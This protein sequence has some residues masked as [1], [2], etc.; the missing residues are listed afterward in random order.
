[1]II[2][3]RGLNIGIQNEIF[4]FNEFVEN[5]IPSNWKVM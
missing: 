4:T 1:M 2:R 3:V 5:P